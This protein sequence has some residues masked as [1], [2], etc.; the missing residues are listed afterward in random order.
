MKDIDVLKDLEK[1]LV[2]NK[3]Y[4]TTSGLMAYINFE[5]YNRIKQHISNQQEEINDRKETE[6]SFMKWV[7]KLQSKLDEIEEVVKNTEGLFIKDKIKQIL[8]DDNMG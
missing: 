2:N 6:Q 1:L 5:E 8:K 7:D 3:S 4:K